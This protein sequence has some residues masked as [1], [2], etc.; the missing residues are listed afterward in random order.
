[1]KK[2]WLSG[3]TMLVAFGLLSAVIA[4]AGPKKSYNGMTEDAAL[5]V[6]VR[7][8][9]HDNVYAKRISL[10]CISYETEETTRTYFEF[11]LRE[12]HNAKCKGDPDTAPIID[13]YRVNRASGKIELYDAPDDR[14]QPYKQGAV[15]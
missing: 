6:L 5:D 12:N 1:M 10:D 14:W 4:H 8:I 3:L 15:R 2:L 11:A 9:K 13:R 7:T